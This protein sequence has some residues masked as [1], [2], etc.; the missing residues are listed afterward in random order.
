MSLGCVFLWDG[1]P[2]GMK[3]CCALSFVVPMW[4]IVPLSAMADQIEPLR[5]PCLIWLWRGLRLVTLLILLRGDDVSC[6]LTW[7]GGGAGS[8]SIE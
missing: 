1:C 4:D 3:A 5:T 2:V 8:D 6:A 7:Q